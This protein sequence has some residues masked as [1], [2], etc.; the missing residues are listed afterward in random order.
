MEDD[1]DLQAV[2]RGC[3]TSTTTTAAAT[4]SAEPDLQPWSCSPFGVKREEEE[5]DHR[6]HF[7]PDPFE[8]R[9]TVEELHELYKPFFPKSQPVSPPQ[10]ISTSLVSG[11]IRGLELQREQ[12][13][14]QKQ[15]K[16]SLVGSLTTTSSTTNTHVPRSKRRKNQLKKVCQVPAESL[17]SDIWSWR[18]YGQKP[19]KGSPYPRGYYR[20]SSSKGCLARKQVERNRSDPAMFIVT[21]TGEHSHPVP[22]HKNSL[23]GI[24]RQ[25]PLTPQTSVTGDS[26]QPSTK[27][28]SCSSPATLST[29]S[30]ED[31]VVQKSTKIETTVKAE[32]ED[33][34]VEDDDEDQLSLSDMVMD[35]DFFLGLDELPNPSAGD[36]FSDHSP[37]NFPL[38]WLANNA[39]AAA[40][41]S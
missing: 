40:G 30:M 19:I 17:S 22:T 6:F 41:S 21:Y 13:Q 4:F 11:N 24:T 34:S 1:W 35:D 14:R 29:A 33:D 39:A 38:P 36:V 15:P 9:N 7:L 26:S 2:V 18:K 10:T 12:I 5:E 16:Q 31:E 27:P 8:T 25:K 28:S 32:E 23:A 3:T 20:C 37:L